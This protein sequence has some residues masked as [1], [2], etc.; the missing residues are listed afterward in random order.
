MANCQTHLFGIKKLK[1]NSLTQYTVHI[2]FIDW[3]QINNW[4]Q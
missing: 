4:R 3:E 1:L 2:S